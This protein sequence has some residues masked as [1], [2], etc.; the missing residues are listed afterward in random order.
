HLA[1]PGGARTAP[2]A[3]YTLGQFKSWGLDASI[4]SFEAL[5]PYPTER[6]VEMIATEPY[7]LKLAE[8]ALTQD[9]T[10]DDPSALPTFNA[11]SADGDVTA[12]LVYVNFGTPEHYEQLAK[13]GAD[14]Q[15]KTV[16]A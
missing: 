8:P 3:E 15:G 11:Y 13:L 12:E 7:R 2:V 9:P 14:V 16:I 4:E 1:R 5:M 10:S 6:V